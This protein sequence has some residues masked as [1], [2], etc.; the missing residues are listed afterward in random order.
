MLRKVRNSAQKCYLAV[1][2]HLKTG[3]RKSGFVGCD[4]Q[5]SILS[6]RYTCMVYSTGRY[7]NT[8]SGVCSPDRHILNS[9]QNLNITWLNLGIHHI[10]N[11]LESDEIRM[12]KEQ[13][14]SHG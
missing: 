2:C 13:L 3:V 9:I 6:S 7:S 4:K 5:Y 8:V 10:C 1:V 14:H 12:I 11:I